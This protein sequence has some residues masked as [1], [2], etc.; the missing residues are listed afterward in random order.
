MI[1][2]IKLSIVVFLCFSVTK[3]IEGQKSKATTSHLT[4]I[5]SKCTE[6]VALY[7]FDGADFKVLKEIS[8]FDQDT[9]HFE[10]PANGPR[11]Y[12]VGTPSGRKRPVI[13][14]LQKEVIV[15]GHCNNTRQAKFI[16]DPL[17]TGYDDLLQSFNNWNSATRKAALSLQK[18]GGEKEKIDAAIQQFAIIDAEKKTFLEQLV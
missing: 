15:K 16:D 7:E 4:A 11:F 14:G 3:K 2:W 17:N 5:F 1:K 18:S 13:L 10:V 8:D 12:Y 9:F 6:S